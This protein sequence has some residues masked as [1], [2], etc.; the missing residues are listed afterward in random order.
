MKAEAGNSAGCEKA[1]L[2]QFVNL[3]LLLVHKVANSGIVSRRKTNIS[4][5][6]HASA[7]IFLFINVSTLSLFQTTLSSRLD[8]PEAFRNLKPTSEQITQLLASL[9]VH[10]YFL[11]NEFH[12]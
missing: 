6:R 9:E 10:K 3:S 8:L 4:N 11:L 1:H 2:F 7:G 12:C 5:G